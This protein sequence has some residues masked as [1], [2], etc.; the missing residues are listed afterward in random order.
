M[1][2]EEINAINNAVIEVI[3]VI[4]LLGVGTFFWLACMGC[5]DKE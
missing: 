1:T 2:V 4:F 3:V 5:F